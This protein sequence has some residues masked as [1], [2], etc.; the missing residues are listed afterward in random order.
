[1]RL[2]ILGGG[3]LGRVVCEIAQRCRAHQVVGF[4][5]DSPEPPRRII[6]LP[7]IGRSDQLRELDLD[8]VI[9]AIGNCAVRR[10][11]AEKVLAAGLDLP[12]IIDPSAIVSPS[13]EIGD[14]VIIGPCV[15]IGPGAQIE[16]LAIVNSSSVIEHDAVLE[17]ACY[18]GPRCLVDARA[19]LAAS[20]MLSDGAVLV[21][22]HRHP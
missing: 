3:G 9:V 6:D 21:Q 7:V 1:M 15:V 19:I 14:G 5:D 17:E 20:T 16:R 8:G 2:A 10:M 18:V 11:L 22:D 13:A 4:I 12:S